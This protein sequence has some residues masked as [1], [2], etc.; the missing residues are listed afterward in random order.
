[1][2]KVHIRRI[3]TDQNKKELVAL[4]NQLRSTIAGQ[5]GYLSSE[6]LRRTD[7]PG[8]ILVVS[9]WQSNFY[10]QQWYA[11]RERKT[12]QD[13]IDRLLEARTQYEIYEF[14]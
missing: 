8:E 10:W 1:M 9:K 14:E 7:P 4:V 12:I 3:V 6:T 13:R 5:P 11:S 2:I